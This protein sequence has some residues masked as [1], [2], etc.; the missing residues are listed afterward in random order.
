MRED[1]QRKERLGGESAINRASRVGSGRRAK[2]GSEAL[3][4]GDG[5]V[6]ELGDHVSVRMKTDGERR[7][8]AVNRRSMVQAEL[9]VEEEQRRAVKLG[10]WVTLK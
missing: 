10:C 4:L 6:T 7:G 9:V 3:V 1:R 8:L 2:M 5:Q